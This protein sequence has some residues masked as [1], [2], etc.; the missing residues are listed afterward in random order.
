[1]RES[2]ITGGYVEWR[3]G[4]GDRIGR[5]AK[6]LCNLLHGV[7][8]SRPEARRETDHRPSHFAIRISATETI[9]TRSQD[10]A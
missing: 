4:R 9:R 1:M 6:N 10:G 7:R 8:F 2:L 3:A 5:R